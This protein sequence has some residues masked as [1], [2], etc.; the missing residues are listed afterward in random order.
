M[1]LQEALNLPNGV[2]VS[3]CVREWIETILTDGGRR[4]KKV[5]LC[6]REWIETYLT[7]VLD[8]N[9]PSLPLREGVD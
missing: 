7:E 3:L 9:K 2:T 5:S 6:V 4:K 1:K 8:D